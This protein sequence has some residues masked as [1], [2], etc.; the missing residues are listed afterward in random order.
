M[1][2][3]M[4]H[5]QGV[6]VHDASVLVTP[7]ILCNLDGPTIVE[8]MDP[9]VI[10]AVQIQIH[11]GSAGLSY[12]QKGAAVHKD[13]LV[14]DVELPV[15]VP[16]RMDEAAIA[17]RHRGEEGAGF[18]GTQSTHKLQHGGHP[19]ALGHQVQVHAHLVDGSDHD[20]LHHAH[21]GRVAGG[22]L[23]RVDRQAEDLHALAA[24]RSQQRKRLEHATAEPCT[25]AAARVCGAT[26][27]LPSGLGALAQ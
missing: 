16:S 27:L 19:G 4:L 9:C 18:A 8:R 20:L 15:H 14:H 10:L 25:A 24:Q 22:L 11:H 26:H 2:H 3:G 13:V 17:L 6:I 23:Q 5:H 12:P 7:R 21:L 1:V